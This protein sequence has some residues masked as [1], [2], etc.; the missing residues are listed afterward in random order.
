[1][2]NTNEDLVS[3]IEALVAEHIASSR[4]AAQEA[5]ERAFAAAASMRAEPRRTKS[6]G[7]RSSERRSKKRRPSAELEA[8][9]EQFYRT[10]CARPGETMTVLAVEVGVSARELHRAVARLKQA[11]RVRTVG[12]R[13]STRYF[14]LGNSAAA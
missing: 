8:L 12:E 1:M 7:A 13:S 6:L 3:R 4:K 11:G 2:T 10:L 14:P 9:G 5:I